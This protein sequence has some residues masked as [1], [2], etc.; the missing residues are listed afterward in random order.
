[1]SNWKFGLIAAASV[2]FLLFISPTAR[3]CTCS[4]NPTV[5]GAFDLADN[6][7]VV[8][9]KGIENS[10]PSS[11]YPRGIKR[12]KATIEKVFKGK[13][14]AKA[15]ISFD[16]GTGSDCLWDAFDEKLTGRKLLVYDESVSRPNVSG[17]YG[18]D[19]CGRS[20]DIEKR[21]VDFLYLENLDRA[22]GRT[23]VYGN[24]Y[25]TCGKEPVADRKVRIIGASETYVATTG[26]NG[27]YELYDLKPGEY[28]LEPEI[29][30]NWKINQNSIKWSISFFSPLYDETKAEFPNRFPIV[31]REKSDA[32]LDFV[33][34]PETEKQ[35]K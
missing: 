13:L 15:E 35:C 27:I 18:I 28:F 7:F 34:I 11:E 4:Q 32:S 12:A 21:A 29:P 1:M 3:A 5:Q 33:Y 6:V 16:E 25:F 31:L 17:R 30:K 10:K 23:R 2:V 26:I 22:R 20:G 24:V 9:I 19:G 14:Q 8:E